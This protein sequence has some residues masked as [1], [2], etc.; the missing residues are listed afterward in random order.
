MTKRKA[1]GSESFLLG[2]YF[3]EEFSSAKISSPDEYASLRKLNNKLSQDSAPI[4]RQKDHEGSP[5]TPCAT[6][7]RPSDLIQLRDLSSR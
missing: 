1:I 3:I 5:G 7:P 6:I 2:N 4:V